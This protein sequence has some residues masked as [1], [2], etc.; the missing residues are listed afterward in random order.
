M[1]EKVWDGERP[2]CDPPWEGEMFYEGARGDESLLQREAKFPLAGRLFSW[3]AQGGFRIPSSPV[4]RLR[5]PPGTAVQIFDLQPL[6]AL[7][8]PSSLRAL[9]TTQ[10]ARRQNLRFCRRGRLRRLGSPKGF[11]PLPPETGCSYVAPTSASPGR[12]SGSQNKF[13]SPPGSLRSP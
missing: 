2:P 4:K 10:K 8:A 7:C 12:G 5:R 13:C 6:V 11:Q 1:A 9:Q 3:R